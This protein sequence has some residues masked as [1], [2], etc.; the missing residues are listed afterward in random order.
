MS[1][2]AGVS[3]SVQSMESKKGSALAGSVKACCF[4]EDMVIHKVAG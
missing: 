2:V 4:P 1:G 3:S